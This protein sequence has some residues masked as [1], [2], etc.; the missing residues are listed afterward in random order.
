MKKTVFVTLMLL[1]FG[2]FSATAYAWWAVSAHAN[3]N[4]GQVHVQVR[5]SYNR[6]IYCEITAFGRTRSGHVLRSSAGG[7]IYPGRIGGA[8][9]YTSWPNTFVRGWGRAQCRW[10]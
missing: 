2:F 8:Y 1:I 4:P 7:V 5:N 9:V 3:V 10:Y 6:P